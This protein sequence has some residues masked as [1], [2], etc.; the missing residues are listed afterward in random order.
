MSWE[1]IKVTQTNNYQI[2]DPIDQQ[3]ADK[4][5]NYQNPHESSNPKFELS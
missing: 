3:T 1:S 2:Y 5:K 4:L